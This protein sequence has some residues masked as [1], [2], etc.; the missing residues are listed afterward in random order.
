MCLDFLLGM[1]ISYH[2]YTILFS[3][4]NPS[5]Y[6]MIWYG[7]TAI[8]PILAYICWYGRSDS[9][10]AIVL[11]SLILFV[12]FSCCFS[13]GWIYFGFKSILDSLVFVG[14]CIVLYQ[15]PKNFMISFVIGL[16]L[17][18]IIRVPYLGG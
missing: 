12:M 4:F 8:S 14:T 9:N 11:D 6:M 15:K 13:M 16:V 2:V 17:A 7:I 18:C 1:C 10:I 5:S 3:G